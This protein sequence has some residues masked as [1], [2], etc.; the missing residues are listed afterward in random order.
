MWNSSLASSSETVLS[1]GSQDF[2]P[3]QLHLWRSQCNPFW[4]F[5][6]Q[7]PTVQRI[8]WVSSQSSHSMWW[9][10]NTHPL[11]F[12]PA[13]SLVCLCARGDSCVLGVWSS[14]SWG[15]SLGS[16]FPV[17]SL[18]S[19]EVQRGQTV[20]HFYHSIFL[21]SANYLNKADVSAVARLRGRGG[22]S[23]HLVVCN[24]VPPALSLTEDR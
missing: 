3:K 8:L 12:V 11:F 10:S 6:T 15:S 13:G 5:Q 16:C 18:W 9:G 22:S 17:P 4:F 14:A 21:L 19:H 2:T 1:D 24:W 20:A 7:A 23:A